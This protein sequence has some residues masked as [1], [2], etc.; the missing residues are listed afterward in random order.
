MS[1]AAYDGI[2]PA[3]AGEVVRIVSTDKVIGRFV[4]VRVAR[5]RD[6]AIVVFE[7]DYSTR[8]ANWIVGE[9]ERKF[10][11]GKLVRISSVR[12]LMKSTTLPNVRERED[13]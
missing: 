10:G 12:A 2:D 8:D 1:V 6:N 4:Q 7:S 9:L 11:G 13:R 3:D 5:K